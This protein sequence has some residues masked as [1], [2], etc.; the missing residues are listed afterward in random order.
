MSEIINLRRARK[1]R[2]RDAAI[3]IAQENR[4]NYGREKSERSRTQANLRRSANI[5]D[6]HLRAKQSDDTV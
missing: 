4:A 1:R 3:L 2:Q 6:A 5:L